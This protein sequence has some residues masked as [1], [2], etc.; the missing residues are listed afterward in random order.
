MS[1]ERPKVKYLKYIIEQVIRYR[2]DKII[3]GI[4]D[5][6]EIEKCF[7]NDK[8]EIQKS[9]P[10]VCK[11]I[12]KNEDLKPIWIMLN[13][14]QEVEDGKVDFKD[15]E[16]NLGQELSNKYIKKIKDEDLKMIKEKG[17]NKNKE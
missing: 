16:K 10:W 13:K 12:I 8:P 2:N 9:Y 15:I 6:I 5:P 3:S 1:Q 4:S 17:M 11:I 14:L 7:I